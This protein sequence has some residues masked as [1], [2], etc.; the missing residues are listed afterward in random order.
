[1]MCKL[2][3]STRI[4]ARGEMTIEKIH[5]LCTG[6][7]FDKIYSTEIGVR[8]FSFPKTSAVTTIV[9]RLHIPNVN[10]TYYP[11]LA[12]DSL[13]MT[14]EDREFISEWCAVRRRTI[15]VHGTDTMIS[16]AHEIDRHWKKCTTTILTGALQP[17]CMQNSDAE[18]NLGSAITAVQILQPGIYIVMHGQIHAWNKC[19]KDPITGLFIPT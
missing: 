19:R 16:T 18:F 15:V 6:G 11:P 13:D 12:K 1:M 5:I 4:D 10:V 2:V 8:N 17:A 3:S 9:E 14:A 7:T